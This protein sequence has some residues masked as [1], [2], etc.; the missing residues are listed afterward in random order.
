MQG[1]QETG[2]EPS[3]RVLGALF[4]ARP[5]THPIVRSHRNSRRTGP[6]PRPAESEL[7]F[8]KIP[9]GVSARGLSKPG[10]SRETHWTAL[11]L[12]ALGGEKPESERGSFVQ[13]V[14]LKVTVAP[15][16]LRGALAV[17][18]VCIVEN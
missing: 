5:Q 8:T 3:V 15:S 6:R 2:R 7:H 11:F 17:W 12:V 14:L 13:K 1:L 10:A 9:R 18:G 4:R 16:A